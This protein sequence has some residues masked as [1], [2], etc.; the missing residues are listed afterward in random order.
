MEK[1]ILTP[2]FKE[3]LLPLTVEWVEKM[4]KAKL[5]GEFALTEHADVAAQ[6]YYQK[7]IPPETY[8]RVQ[9][10]KDVSNYFLLYFRPDELDQSFGAYIANGAGVA[11]R[12]RTGV[13][14]KEGKF[15]Y[16]RHRHDLVH[17][18]LGNFIDGGDSYTRGTFSLDDTLVQF[19]IV[20]GEI[21]RDHN[22]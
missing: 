12:K 9:N 8:E 1:Q 17:Y 6:L 4:Y 2:S 20:D 11:G 15:Y 21:V 10:P 22:V 14:T 5:V 3:N 19:S 18:G 13:V 16:S 7:V